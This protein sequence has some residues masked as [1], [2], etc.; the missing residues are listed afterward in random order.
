MDL[1]KLSLLFLML[2]HFCV[3]QNSSDSESSTT[4]STTPSYE[5]LPNPD[6]ILCN[7]NYTDEIVPFT[8]SFFGPWGQESKDVE[9]EYIKR[10]DFVII[11]VPSFSSA[12]S[13]N[14]PMYSWN[15]PPEI[16]PYNDMKIIVMSVLDRSR[17]NIGSIIFTFD[18]SV[19]ISVGFPQASFR[20]PGNAGFFPTTLTYYR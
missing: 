18:G 6:E 9:F 5:T 14:L 2:S 15:L 4:D 19:T 11:N 13:T 10:G 20:A 7:C 1:I 12:V 3:S 16:A 8:L 17:I